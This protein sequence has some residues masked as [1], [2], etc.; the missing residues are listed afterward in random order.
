MQRLVRRRHHP[1]IHAQGLVVAH[2]L[3]F[4]RLQ[5]AQH[6]RLQRQR[7]LADLVQKQRASVRCFDPP[8]RDCT[9]PVNAPRVCPNNSAS[10]NASGIAAQFSTTKGLLARAL[11]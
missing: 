1:H 3:Q 7:H 11:R 9:A 10:S 8:V 5:K 6:L 2:P 4:A